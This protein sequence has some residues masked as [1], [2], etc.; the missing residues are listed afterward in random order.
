V[1]SRIRQF[2]RS[3]V[4]SWIRQFGRSHVDSRIRQFGRSHV[5]SRIRQF[6]RSHV[7]SRIV[8]RGSDGSKS[9]L[10]SLLESDMWELNLLHTKKL[11]GAAPSESFVFSQW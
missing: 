10:Y 5:D 9:S 7:D 4:D 6:G 1:D 3:H 8:L 2:G 11:R